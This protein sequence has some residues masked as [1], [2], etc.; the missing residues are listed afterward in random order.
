MG[1][2]EKKNFEGKTETK[3]SNQNFSNFK[4][5]IFQ[6]TKEII[7]YYSHIH[8]LTMEHI[9]TYTHTYTSKNKHKNYF[10]T[11]NEAKSDAE[12]HIGEKI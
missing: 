8:M 9:L 6:L 2:E 4:I 12:Q 5:L 7:Y 10:Q 1:F 11:K 3:K